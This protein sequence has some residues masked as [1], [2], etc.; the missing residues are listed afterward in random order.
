M[1]APRRVVPT[2]TEPLAV[3]ASRLVGGPLGRHGLVG[4]S[5]FWTPLRVVLLFA[6]A[7]LS[8]G[9]LG[10]AA[11]LQQYSPAEGGVALDWRADRQ[12][13]AMCYSDSI[14]LYRLEGMDAGALPYRDPWPG[15]QGSQVRYSEHPVLTGFAQWATARVADGWLWLGERL[16]LWPGGLPE[17][18]YFDLL[19][20]WLSFA[21]L[22]VVWAV[23]RLRPWRPWDAAL[24]ALS[25][26]ALVH[27][28]TASDAAAVA[29]AAAALLALARGRALLAGALLGVGGGFGLW[30]MFLLVPVLLVAARRRDAT[31][32][33]RVAGAAVGTWAA[34]NVPVALAFPQGWIEMFRMQVVRPADVDSL[35]FAV[36]SLTGR[37][38][39]D[40][41][42]PDGAAPVALNTVTLVLVL[43]CCVAI[44]VLAW[45]APQPPRL[46]SLAFLL[47]AA[48]LLTGKAWSPQWSLWLVPLA[49][50]ALPRWRLLLA[51]MTV[52]A[53]LWAPRMFFFL[54]PDGRGLTPEW[55]L[56]TVLVRDAV[57]VGLC[58][59]V[60][61]SVLHPQTDPVRTTAGAGA[62]ADPEWP[63]APDEP[64]PPADVRAAAP[65]AA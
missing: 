49:V 42:L 51:W 50:L 64:R 24:V 11:C 5:A 3:S 35:W 43:V 27:V 52:D 44:A 9:W 23:F 15:S 13:V 58:V 25:P 46:A 12:Y 38:G 30:P 55:F 22:V 4:R 53:L 14:P 20:V 39:L 47:V 29:C 28:L 16:P 40:G 62:A 61:R 6:V 65:A 7:V 57:V 36:A 26:L 2:W 59:L 32:G 63:A 34:V 10:K 45:R 60:V 21:W 19:A 17:V 1:N 37:P 8:L 56:G 31:T 54:G 48:L 33:V 41:E 18:V